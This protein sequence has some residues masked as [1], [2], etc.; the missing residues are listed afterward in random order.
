MTSPPDAGSVASAVDRIA[1]AWSKRSGAE[2]AA[3][4]NRVT[5]RDAPP[6]P[7]ASAA[8][9]VRERAALSGAVAPGDLM[10]GIEV[11][12]DETAHLLEV[13]APEFDRTYEDGGWAWTQRS[14][15]RRDTLARLAAEGRVTAALADTAAIP[16]DAAGR[17]LR[18]LATDGSPPP[19]SPGD[20]P[21]LAV[22]ALAWAAPLG[23]LAGHL[24]EARRQARVRSLAASYDVLLR[25]GFYGRAEVLERLRTFAD[26]PV[27]GAGAVPLRV[28]TGIGG[29]G[30]STVLAEFM[31]PYLARVAAADPEVADAD[32]TAVVV[33]DFD[34]LQFRLD[35][36]LEL[37]FEVSRQLGAAAPVAGADFS[38]LRYQFREVR[39]VAGGDVWANH[40]SAENDSRGALGFERD[41]GLLVRMHGLDRRR[42]LL[43]LDTFEEWQRDRPVAD[44]DRK[45]GNDPEARVLAWIDRLRV[46]MGLTGLRVVV[47]G[48]A[49]IGSAGAADGAGA[50][51]TERLGDLAP[52]EAR[53][54]L[55]GL[56]LNPQQ[57]T[58]LA[59]VVGGN[60]LTLRVAAR[61]FGR[62]DPVERE[63]F[64]DGGVEAAEGLDG[65]IRRAVLYD[66]F[67][68]HIS[69]PRVRT[70][71]HPGLLLRRVTPALVRQVLA[72]LCGLGPIDEDEAELLTRRLADEVWLVK[73]TPDGLRHQPDVRRA[74]VRLMADDDTYAAAAH[75]IH[76]AAVAWYDGDSD[77]LPREQ[78]QVEAFYHRL[79]LL[80]R[81]AEIPPWMLDAAGLRRAVALGESVAELPPRIA[82]QVRV[83]RGDDVTGADADA[84]P[85][86][87]WARWVDRRGGAL[88]EADEAA[89]ALALLGDREPPTEPEWLAQACCDAGRWPAYWE[90]VGREEAFAYTRVRRYAAVNAIASGWDPATPHDWFSGYTDLADLTLENLFF[91]L[92]LDPGEARNLVAAMSTPD[93]GGRTRSDRFP[94][95]QMRRVLTWSAADCPGP[96]V[97][98]S[99]LAGLYRPD[100]RWVDDLG[101]LTGSPAPA[102]PEGLRTDQILGDWATSF[103]R[104]YEPLLLQPLALRSSPGVV[105]LLRGDNPELRPAIRAALES[106]P[107]R[108]LAAVAWDLLPIRPVDLVP[109]VVPADD[110]PDAP[111]VR[112]RLAEYVDRSGV[113]G[114]FLAAV[115][116]AWPTHEAVA[117]AHTAFQR[118]DHAH[119]RLFESLTDRLTSSPQ[120]PSAR[121]DERPLPPPP[122]NLPGP[123][124]WGEVTL[125]VVTTPDRVRPLTHDLVA[126]LAAHLFP[127]TARLHPGTVQ[128]GAGDRAVV[129][130]EL[131][132]EELTALAAALAD[133]LRRDDVDAVIVQTDGVLVRLEAGS[134]E[135]AVAALLGR[136]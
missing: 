69:D 22:Q 111:A 58:A 71:A 30:K 98:L 127:V 8:Q 48:R 44:A 134:T 66:R 53:G 109:D 81:D 133:F 116:A 121:P 1:A 10:V 136:R 112:G 57:A 38:A 52:E 7:S 125:E 31:R 88:V 3:F 6:A 64:L 59:T 61:F 25:H 37:S 65:D 117:D 96:A 115:H 24:A 99:Q 102:M 77:D 67:L 118:W 9:R 91:A 36:E 20:P 23:G 93:R 122:F 33:I 63:G 95:D 54:L 86:A 2:Q 103:A 97:D 34:R 132:R 74:M 42:V 100:P 21:D 17:A 32:T 5:P 46:H 12:D 75:A 55:E 123:A 108:A 47:S 41:A 56:G 105:R 130:S 15:T 104:L 27:D 92:L 90:A 124:R 128:I 60:P 72:P 35:A 80:D 79:M 78:A 85:D 39:R 106:L 18:G 119:D 82:A 135:A 40:V 110:A 13:L 62:L 49:G 83:L 107:L 29:A 51:Q 73:E 68:G 114:P 16:T 84:L 70:L 43:V 11:D 129:R 120:S 76:E 89:Q 126:T 131:D 113:T 28:V 94:V 26:S 45:P 50:V 14:T 4:A 101:A 19:P 87:V